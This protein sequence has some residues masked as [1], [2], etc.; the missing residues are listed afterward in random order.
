MD[1][2]EVCAEPARNISSAG[3]NTHRQ[4]ID[5]ADRYCPNIAIA[6]TKSCYSTSPAGSN[7]QTQSYMFP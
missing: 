1:S 3:N 7:R 6:S 5:G 2:E 4:V